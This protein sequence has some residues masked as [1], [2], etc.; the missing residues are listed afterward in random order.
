MPNVAVPMNMC[1]VVYSRRRQT[2][3]AT[4]NRFPWMQMMDERKR[5]QP[6]LAASHFGRVLG[7]WDVFALSFGAMVG[8][9][10]VILSGEWIDT[11]G[12]AGTAAAFLIGGGIMVLVGLIYAELASALP[13]VGGEHVYTREAFGHGTAFVCAW[14]ILFGYVSVVAFEAIALPVALAWLFPAIRQGELWTVA[15]YTV[16]LGEVLIGSG[17]AIAMTYINLLGVRLA[18]RAQAVAVVIVVAGGAILVSG[19]GLGALP[20]SAPARI[21]TGWAGVAGVVVAV[22]FLFV[23]FDVVPQAA[24]EIGTKQR[25][26]GRIMMISIVAAIA[27]YVAVSVTTGLGGYAAGEAVP[28]AASA[29]RLWGSPVAGIIIVVAGIAGIL[30]S[31]NAFLI[32]GTRALFALAESGATP[33]WLTRI[34]PRFNTPS[35]AIL[36][37]GSLSVPA[38]LLGRN[39]LVWIVDAG[40]F[41]I[42]LCYALVAAAFITL[43]RTAPDMNRPYRAPGQGRYPWVGLSGLLL[44]GVLLLLYLPWSP[45]GLTWQ[46]WSMVGGW[47]ALGLLLWIARGRNAEVANRHRR[48]SKNTHRR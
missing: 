44:A 12:I 13:F 17:V 14:A 42:V 22:P 18:S 11:A 19:A 35:A 40:A 31:W 21:W 48:V 2:H 29:S 25:D 26:I 6:E 5:S 24:E 47:T 3:A 16:T 7:R 28:A 33:A 4:F 20:E 27:F 32:G 30:T 8:W 46:E 15:G 34:H 23:G 38:P 37:I 36:I 10:W 41:G 39:A 45:A 9:S 1:S 43:R